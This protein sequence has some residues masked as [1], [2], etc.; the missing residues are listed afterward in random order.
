MTVCWTGEVAA[1]YHV[2]MGMLQQMIRLD[3]G[4]GAG[5][6]G[7]SATAAQN[8]RAGDKGQ[9]DGK[10]RATTAA[11]AGGAAAPDAPCDAAVSPRSTRA[12]LPGLNAAHLRLA[13]PVLAG[14][15]VVLVGASL[16]RLALWKPVL[17]APLKEL[18]QL[19]EDHSNAPRD[20]GSD[21][22]TMDVV[23]LERQRW[24]GRMQGRGVATIDALRFEHTIE[25]YLRQRA[26]RN[27]AAERTPKERL[28]AST[29]AGR[30]LR[31]VSFARTSSVL[32]LLFLHRRQYG[33]QPPICFLS[34][35]LAAPR[36]A[37]TP[38]TGS[39]PCCVQGGASLHGDKCD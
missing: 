38:I 8:A 37:C 33:P 22:S 32:L 14:Q 21:A 23:A 20:D 10:T 9:V 24:I 35:L 2:K 5:A 26:A 3:D 19:H 39:K 1:I 7:P 31:R 34:P 12:E 36:T 27:P 18:N 17:L 11:A 16:P 30:G 29:K 13:R 15:V 25:P 6:A 4:S 28:D